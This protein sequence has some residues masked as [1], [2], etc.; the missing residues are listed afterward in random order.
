M[1][2]ARHE[3]RVERIDEAPGHVCVSLVPTLERDSVRH[4]R[5]RTE[6]LERA[7]LFARSFRPMVDLVA[8]EDYAARL[9]LIARYANDGTFGC[10]AQRGRWSAQTVGSSTKTGIRRSVLV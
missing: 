10:F 1:D 2:K 8:M 3:Y 6:V 9:S 5:A 7:V 4:L